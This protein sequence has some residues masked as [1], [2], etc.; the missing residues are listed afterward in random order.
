MQW[1]ESLNAGFTTAKPWLPVPDSY[2]THNVAT[3]LQEPDSV[4][5]F[6][7]HLLAL[8]HQNQALLDGEYIA[9]NN[10]DPNVLSYLR[11]YKGQA[12]LVVLNMSGQ[13]QKASFD[14]G[15]QGFPAASA[16]TL[17]TTASSEAPTDLSQLSLEPFGVYIAEISSA[18]KQ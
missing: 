7:K 8:R 6:Y 1:N 3:E 12:V 18:A 15:A 11:K 10:D 17:L 5:Q 16:K 9:L 2:K 4:L 14:L 13:A